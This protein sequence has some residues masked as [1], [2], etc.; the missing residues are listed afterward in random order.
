MAAF[1]HPLIPVLVTKKLYLRVTDEVNQSSVRPFLVVEKS[2]K[3][4][5][6]ENGSDTIFLNDCFRGPVTSN[7]KVVFHF[8][9]NM[10]AQAV[11]KK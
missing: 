2:D 11:K 5:L 8:V 6:T 7:Q 10:K 1:Y 9:M 3:L 4:N